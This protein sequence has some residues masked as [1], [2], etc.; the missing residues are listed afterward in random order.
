M[1]RVRTEVALPVPYPDEDVALLGCTARDANGPRR[2]RAA[3]D[4]RLLALAGWRREEALGGRVEEVEDAAADVDQKLEE[5]PALTWQRVD[6]AMASSRWIG[7]RRGGPGPCPSIPTSS[8]RSKPG[9]RSRRGR[10]TPISCLSK[11]AAPRSTGT[12]PR[13]SCARTPRREGRPA[14]SSTTASLRSAARCGCT[15]FARR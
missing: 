6:F 8:A 15:T 14:P 2:S 1:Q 13:G 5:V 12:T 3:R 4:V 9:E 10:R 11:R 7:R